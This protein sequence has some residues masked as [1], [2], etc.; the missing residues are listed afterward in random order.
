MS[1]SWWT[2]G[3][4]CL[5]DVVTVEQCKCAAGTLFSNM[6][7]RQQDFLAKCRAGRVVKVAVQPFGSLPAA[8]CDDCSR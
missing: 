2:N 1:F 6:A 3:A 4:L 8:Q 7:V 5:L